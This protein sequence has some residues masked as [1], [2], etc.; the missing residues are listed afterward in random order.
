MEVYC[1]ATGYQHSQ[2]ALSPEVA[3]TDSR[4]AGVRLQSCERS[5]P[6]AHLQLGPRGEALAQALKPQHFAPPTSSSVY[7]PETT[8]YRIPFTAHDFVCQVL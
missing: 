1:S 3:R 2:G 4:E 8:A 7:R 6:R 5:I